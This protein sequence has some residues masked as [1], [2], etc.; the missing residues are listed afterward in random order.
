MVLIHGFTTIPVQCLSVV[1]V[2]GGRLAARTLLSYGHREIAVI[3]GPSSVPD[4]VDRIE[5]F[6]AELNEAG[7]DTGQMWVAESNFASQ[8]G[9][10]AAKEL[11]ASDYPFTAVFCANDEMAVGALSYF[12]GAGVDVPGAV[13]VHG[14]DDVEGARFTVPRLSSVHIPWNEMAESGLN[15]L[16]NRCYGL[17]RPVVSQFPINAT[18]RA[19]VA[20]ARSPLP[21][22]ASVRA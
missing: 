11:L 9:W 5:G 1:L 12:H 10:A 15:L 8:G 14:Y 16:L 6:L 22:R 13:S 17:A 18:M 7:I 19:S 4:N 21:R 2:L 3:A 20:A